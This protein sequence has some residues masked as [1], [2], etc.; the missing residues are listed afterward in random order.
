MSKKALQS[1]QPSPKIQQLKELLE[2][3]IVY[4]DGA[5]GTMIQTYKLDEND[6]EENASK[7]I[8]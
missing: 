5:M 8:Q 3:R 6:F 1:K 7:T 2:K 4:L